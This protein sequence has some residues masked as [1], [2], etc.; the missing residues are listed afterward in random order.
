MNPFSVAIKIREGI[1][2]FI[3]Y[4]KPATSGG[5]VIYVYDWLAWE[6]SLFRALFT[7]AVRI[8]ADIT[9]K[10]KHVLKRVTRQNGY[11]LFHVN[12]TDTSKFFE[13]KET[14]CDALKSRNITCLNKDITNISKKFVQD[15]CLFL[16]LNSTR[17]FQDGD[18]DE[19]LI[20]KTNDNFG[21]V[22]EAILTVAQKIK[23]GITAAISNPDLNYIVTERCTIEQNIWDDSS[24]VIEQYISNA[25]N[26]YYRI[27][28]VN[29]R[30]AISEASE[31]GLI[32]KMPDGIKRTNYFFDTLAED[33]FNTTK[34]D[35]TELYFIINKFCTH[36]K[37]DFG[38]LDVVRNDNNQFYIIDVNTTPSWGRKLY[39][40]PEL[41]EFLAGG[42]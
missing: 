5:P 31:A 42:L 41:F 3:T 38:A 36:I 4:I 34:A 19:L 37:L 20:I 35:M 13:D 11:F 16:G 1:V 28:K 29:N 22:N 21:G 23:L 12:L 24:R 18:P 6:N 40:E 33:S 10:N 39:P 2:S 14:L 15:A 25:D 9:Q 8:K 32:K 7:S 27:Y 17:A 26:L 30:T